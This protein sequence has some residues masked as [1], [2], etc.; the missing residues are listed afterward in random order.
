I[1]IMMNGFPPDFT[2]EFKGPG[3]NDRSLN[4]HAISG[5]RQLSNMRPDSQSELRFEYGLQIAVEQ[6]ILGANKKV[7]KKQ[8]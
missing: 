1:F 6:I 2:A 7:A 8:A 4:S 5:S 3:N